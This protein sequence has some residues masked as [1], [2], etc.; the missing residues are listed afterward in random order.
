MEDMLSRLSGNANRKPC[1]LA[2]ATLGLSGEEP[3]RWRPFVT[4]VAGTLA[5][6]IVG[7]RY[8]AV[9]DVGAPRGRLVA[10][11]LNDRNPNN[12]RRWQE[13]VPQSDAVLRTVTEFVDTYSRVRIVDRSGRICGHVPLPGRS[14]INELPIPIMNLSPRGHPEEFV[15]AFSSLTISPGIYSH[16]PG[17]TKLEVLREPK[18][19]LKDAVVEDHT[20]ISADGTRIPYRLVRRAD[21]SASEPQPALLY[22]YGG[23][24]VACSPQFPG[25]MAAFVAAGGMYVHAHLRGGAEFGR[26]WWQGGRMTHKHNCY[27]DL[28]AIAEDLIRAKRSAPDRLA[29]TGAS[30]GGLMAGVA[31]TQRPDLWKVVVPRVPVLDLIGACREPYS[32][33]YVSEEFAEIEKPDEV[34]RLASFSPYHLV[35]GRVR[36]PAVFLE[37]GDTDPRCPPWHARKFAARLQWATAGDAPIL[38]HVWENAGH[39]PATQ[40]GIAVTQSTEWLAFTLRHL[41]VE[42]WT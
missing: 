15:F 6:H 26:D 18:V 4:E 40:K 11:D 24:N 13:L 30:N 7:E 25:P 32:R 29:V 5:G 2:V 17:E 27:N 39:G 37:A 31:L 41:G 16:T 21:V 12:P 28:Y 34:R 33:Q 14:A 20:A 1:P 35:R 19:R 9:T 8:I 36:Y 42:G 3:L 22:G 10:I 23:F 38:L